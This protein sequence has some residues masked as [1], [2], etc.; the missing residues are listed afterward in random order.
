M[1]RYIKLEIDI[2]YASDI[3]ST[4]SDVTTSGV[5]LPWEKANPYQ[6]TKMSLQ[7]KAYEDGYDL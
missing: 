5:V 7:K 6:L 4:S 3:I 2:S 1:K